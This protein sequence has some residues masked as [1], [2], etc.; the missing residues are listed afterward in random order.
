MKYDGLFDV[1]GRFKNGPTTVFKKFRQLL[2]HYL[3][4]TYSESSKEMALFSNS[5]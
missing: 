5:S 4:P 3:R 1:K 2:D